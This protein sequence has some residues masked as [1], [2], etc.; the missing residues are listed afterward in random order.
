[1]KCSI[2]RN[3]SRFLVEIRCE[4]HGEGGGTVDRYEVDEVFVAK[5]KDGDPFAQTTMFPGKTGERVRCK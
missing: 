1:M 2:K 5:E 3:G 4:D